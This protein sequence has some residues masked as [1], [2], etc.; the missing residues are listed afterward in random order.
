MIADGAASEPGE[1]TNEA[2]LR[3]VVGPLAGPTICRL[4][5]ILIGRARCPLDRLDDAMLVCDAIV[6]HAP[7]HLAGGQLG[8]AVAVSDSSLELRVGPLAERGAEAV[9]ADATIPGIGNVLTQVSDR[10][11]VRAVP[12]GEELV[13]GLD[14]DGAGRPSGPV[15][16]S[17]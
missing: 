5:S 12:G 15:G 13:I 8:V 1:A 3:M 10:V 2:T 4:V 6:D 11:D 17:L 7:A 16:L 9:L 14:F